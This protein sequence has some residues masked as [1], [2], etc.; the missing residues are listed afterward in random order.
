MCKPSSLLCAWCL[1]NVSWHT[2]SLNFSLFC[3][4]WTRC[5]DFP[6]GQTALQ[7][8]T[9]IPC[10]SATIFHPFLYTQ[11]VSPWAEGAW[12]WLPAPQK[13]GSQRSTETQEPSFISGWISLGLQSEHV[14]E[15]GHLCCN[16]ITAKTEVTP[17]IHVARERGSMLARCSC[18]QPNRRLPLAAE[19]FFDWSASC[20]RQLTWKRD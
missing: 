18:F 7:C 4:S 8:L 2:D 10:F 5:T 11:Q 20:R 14:D 3:V 13:P 6:T 9:L 15:F 12:N 16:R 1:L 19:V 17:N